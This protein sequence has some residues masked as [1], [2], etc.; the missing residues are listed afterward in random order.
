MLLQVPSLNA[1]GIRSNWQLSA[2]KELERTVKEVNLFVQVRNFINNLPAV[3][4]YTTQRYN[5]LHVNE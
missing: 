2:L 4:V 5:L 1:V 3:C